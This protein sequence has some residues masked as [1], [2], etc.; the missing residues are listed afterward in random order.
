MGRRIKTYIE[1]EGVEDIHRAVA[2]LEFAAL[3]EVVRVVASSAAVIE[4]DAKAAC[5][6]SE[7]S[8]KS[9]K[10]PYPSGTTRASIKTIL[11]DGG[12]TATIGSGW[13]VARF[14]EQ[15]VNGRPARPFL[16][17]AFQSE[18]TRYLAGIEKAVGKAS[19]ESSTS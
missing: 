12:L 11:R 13:F 4:R 3:R 8:T 1:M 2:R 14:I 5:P 10:N 15:G 16:N 18:R 7:P 19:K 6:V 9:A 17:P